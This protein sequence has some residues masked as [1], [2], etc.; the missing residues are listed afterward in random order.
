VAKANAA[1]SAPSFA[2]MDFPGREV[3]CP[4]EIAKRLG[5]CTR[6]VQDL[7]QEG[8]L[9][10]VDISRR[11]TNTDRKT[12]RVPIESWRQFLRERTI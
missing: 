8:Q 12:I 4:F 11:N 1:S 10:A 5:C 7:I 3:L 2:S 9:R 6:H